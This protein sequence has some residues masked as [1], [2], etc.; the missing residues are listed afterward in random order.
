MDGFLINFQK[1]LIKKSVQNFL[2]YPLTEFL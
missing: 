2:N 1:K